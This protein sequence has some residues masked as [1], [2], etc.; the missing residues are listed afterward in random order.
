MAMLEMRAHRTEAFEYTRGV[1]GSVTA[2]YVLLA[3]PVIADKIFW[4]DRAASNQ[5]QYDRGSW[6]TTH[7][8]T[9]L[10]SSVHTLKFCSV[11]G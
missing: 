9:A 4:T 6:S 7:H 1:I 8:G 3:C 5:T 10:T 2:C 11:A